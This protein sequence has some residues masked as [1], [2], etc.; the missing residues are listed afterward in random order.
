MSRKIHILKPVQENEIVDEFGDRFLGLPDMLC[1]SVGELEHW[2][3]V[4]PKPA[5]VDDPVTCARCRRIFKAN[6]EAAYRRANPKK[7]LIGKYTGRRIC[8]P[9]Y[10]TRAAEPERGIRLD[11]RNDVAGRKF[12]EVYRDGSICPTCRRELA[13]RK[14]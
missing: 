2:I 7:H 10:E 14:S 13:K 4:E 11:H 8:S 1:G 5:D 6:A 9:D 12:D 3:Q